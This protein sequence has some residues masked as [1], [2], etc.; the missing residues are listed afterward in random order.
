MESNEGREEK[1]GGV[2]GVAGWLGRENPR[3]EGV[4]EVLK[5][6]TGIK[7]EGCSSAEVN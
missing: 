3:G 4:K 5:E 7:K 2:V 6:G 1:G